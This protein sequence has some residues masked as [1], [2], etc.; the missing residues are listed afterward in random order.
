MRSGVERKA[1]DTDNRRDLYKDAK[2][3]IPMIS[4]FPTSTKNTEISSDATGEEVV[5]FFVSLLEKLI[6]VYSA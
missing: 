6:L 3:D 4:V 1:F 5:I 2:N